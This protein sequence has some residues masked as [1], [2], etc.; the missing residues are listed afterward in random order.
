MISVRRPS[1]ALVISCVALASRAR[2]AP[3]TRRS[4]PVPTQQRR[5]P[6]AEELRRDL[7]EGAR[8]ARCSAPTSRVRPAAGRCPRARAG[9]AGATVLHGPAGPAG[10][11]GARAGRGDVSVEHRRP[12]EDRWRSTCPTGKPVVRRRSAAQPAVH[13]QLAVQQAFPTTTIVFRA[14]RARGRP[15]RPRTG[16][17]RCS[18]S[19]RPQLHEA[20]RRGESHGSPREYAD[21]VASEAPPRT[22]THR[23]RARCSFRAGSRERDLVA[24]E[25]PLEIRIGDE[26]VAVTMRTP[27][28]RRGARA[29]LLPHGGPRAARSRAAR[30]P[31][32]EHGRGRGAAASIP[33]GSRRQLLHVVLV[34]RLREGRARGGRGRARRASRATLARRVRRRRASLPE[35]LRA[36]QRAFDG[37][38]RAARDRALRRRRRAALRARG[39]RPAQRDGQGR[40]L[41][42]PRGPLPL[43]RAILLRQRPA[44]ASSSCR[45]RP[46]P[47]CPVSSP[48]ARRRRSRSSS[49]PT[50]ASRL[51]GCVRDGRLTVYTEPWRIA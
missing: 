21:R 49:R 9:L 38:R 26:P 3:V 24:V 16:R 5:D 25:E 22:P 33:S 8:T 18:R 29:R 40:R 31:R 13:A 51:C 35:R 36:A 42:V 48:S 1:P 28:S 37:D 2:V 12:A 11:S 4:R 44:L 7:G 34:R 47:G 19:A 46:S 41:G 30:R 45:R 15:R 17:S 32:R 39:R 14:T 43:A 23:R 50:A 6:A 10:L 20:T 27:G